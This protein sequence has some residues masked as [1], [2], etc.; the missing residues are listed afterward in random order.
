[1]NHTA[2]AARSNERRIY[3]LS[4]IAGSEQTGNRL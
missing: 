3:F 4:A 2:E 1:M